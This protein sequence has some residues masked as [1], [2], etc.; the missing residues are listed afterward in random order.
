[1]H[2]SASE[3]AKSEPE[4]ADESPLQ[5]TR[6]DE[7]EADGSVMAAGVEMDTST[8]STKPRRE[9]EVDGE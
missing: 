5:P 6:R 7:E 2:R 8:P 9:G 1:M 4:L 3:P